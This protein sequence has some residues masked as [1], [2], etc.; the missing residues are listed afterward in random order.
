M[1]LVIV[2]AANQL[3]NNPLRSN[4]GIASELTAANH[5]QAVVSSHYLATE[6]GIEILNAGGSAADA[7]VA[8][9]A[10][11]SVVEPWFSSALGGGTWALYYDADNTEVT[12][13]DGVGYA[14]SQA[15]LANY[16][17]RV[18]NQGMHQAI[19][20]GAWDG[21][22]RWLSRYGRL[23]LK[24]VLAPAIRIARDGFPAS[25]EMVRWLQS[26][27]AQ[28]INTP[29]MARI[30]APNGA[31][32]REGDTVYQRDMARTF[33]ALALA[34]EMA[35]SRGHS[36]AIQAARDHFYRGPLAQAIVQFSDQN[37]GYFTLA[38][39]QNFEA[40]IVEPISI[41]YNDEITVYQNPP[42]SQGIAML[43]ALNMMKGFNLAGRSP[44]DVDA[45]HLQVEAIKLAFADRYHHVGDPARVNVPVSGLLSDA[46]A[47]SQRRRI[48]INM[49]QAWPIQD[50]LDRRL[51]HHTTTFHIVDRDGNAAAVTTSLGA[52]FLVIG[53]TGIHINERMK[54]FSLE[55]GNPNVMEAGKKVRHTSSPYMALRNGKPYILGGN[56]GVDTQPQGQMQQFLNVVEFGLSAQ[57]AVAQPR[58]VSTAFPS[59]RYPHAVGNTLQLES[60]FSTATANQLRARGHN[61]AIG[62]GTFGSANMIVVSEDGVTV[63]TG[64][65]PRDS[66][67]RGSVV[68]VGEGE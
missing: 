26:Q 12:S 9:A 60:S 18:Q 55:A 6:A 11:L 8:V 29:N 66:T 13:L 33:L 43:L 1:A 58:F 48:D 61:V 53:D 7:A 14:G 2:F 16:R 28:I 22:M 64:A 51:V 63:Q 45:V 47:D 44:T 41:A 24:D 50:G 3:K 56:T 39:F 25:P 59:T 37:N 49:A 15:T 20:P 65:D 38:D 52:Q 10:V 23:E 30:Y 62:Q 21:W 34:Y 17:A 19:V 31:L 68:P 4:P 40:E 35:K 42:N 57:E 46:H 5:T 27:S 36:E 54:F 67:S 32:V